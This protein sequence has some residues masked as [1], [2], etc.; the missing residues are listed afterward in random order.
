MTC[1][2]CAGTGALTC[3]Q[4]DKREWWDCP[5]CGGAGARVVFGPALFAAGGRKLG[6][7]ET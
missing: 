4:G 6:K 7:E 2:L 5:A 3:L 1:K